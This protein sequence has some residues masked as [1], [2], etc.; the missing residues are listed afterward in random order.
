[1]KVLVTGP[2]KT[3]DCLGLVESKKLYHGLIRS[4]NQH[5]TENVVYETMVLRG[6][7]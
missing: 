2:S 5:S 7:A 6:Y 4:M 3:E 1:M